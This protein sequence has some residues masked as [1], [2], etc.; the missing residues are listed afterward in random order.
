MSWSDGAHWTFVCQSHLLPGFHFTTSV[1]ITRGLPMPSP[2]ATLEFTAHFQTSG[3]TGSAHTSCD[4]FKVEGGIKKE[5][6]KGNTFKR[7]INHLNH[8][9]AILHFGIC[10]KCRELFIKASHVGNNFLSAF[11][12]FQHLHLDRKMIPSKLFIMS[13][14]PFLKLWPCSILCRMDA[15]S[16]TTLGI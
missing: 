15:L 11:T 13:I 10:L 1:L 7:V 4:C 5:K 16:N 2:T 12:P 14:H 8:M 3:S 9:E 6:K